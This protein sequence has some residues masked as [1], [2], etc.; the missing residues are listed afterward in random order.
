MKQ[1][2]LLRENKTKKQEMAINFDNLLL[3]E[4][5]VLSPVSGAEKESG[6]AR[7]EARSSR[8]RRLQRKERLMHRRDSGLLL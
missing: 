1:Q 4:D 3:E 2:F 5:P 7:F 6:G 8:D